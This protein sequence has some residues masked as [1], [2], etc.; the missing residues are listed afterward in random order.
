MARNG[1]WR[2]LV[3]FVALAFSGEAVGD[4]SKEKEGVEPVLRHSDTPLILDDGHRI[5]SPCAAQEVCMAM[6]RRYLKSI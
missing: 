3:V 2:V 4:G 5:T 1:G 6:V